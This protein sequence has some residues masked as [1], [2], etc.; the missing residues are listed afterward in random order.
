M[1]VRAVKFRVGSQWRVGGL[2][3]PRAPG[4]RPA[5]LFLHGFPGVQKNED[6]AAELCRRGAVGFVPH[7]GGGWG[8]AGLF[9]VTGMLA[10]AQAALRLLRRYRH[11]DGGRAAVV[12]L[13]L[14]GWA[15]LRLAGAGPLSAVAVMAPAVWPGPPAAALSEARRGARVLNMPPFSRVAS[16]YARAMQAPPPEDYLG[17]IAPAPLLLVQGLDDT[18]VP[19]AATRRVWALAAEPKELVELSGEAHEFQKD[20]A[21]AVALVAGWLERRLGLGGEDG[22]KKASTMIYP[23]ATTAGPV[24]S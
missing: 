18:V 22:V 4:R 13:S 9:S 20:R 23:S 11:V 8:S 12:G 7:F 16:D 3:S 21:G 17:R 5:V 15:A 10:D 1:N 14:G 6:I 2:Y 19:P 24:H